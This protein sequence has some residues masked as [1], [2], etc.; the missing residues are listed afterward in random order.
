MLSLAQYTVLESLRDRVY[1]AFLIILAGL[2][3]FFVLL[4]SAA[5]GLHNYIVERLGWMTID[6][7]LAIQTSIYAV[8]NITRERDRRIL[9]FHLT[10]PQSRGFYLIGKTLGLFAVTTALA[11]LGT[12]IVFFGDR[13]F[14]YLTTW[15]FE[16]FW[17][18]PSVLLKNAIL[19]AYALFFVHIT[20]SGLTASLLTLATYMIGNASNELLMLAEK[21]GVFEQRIL[22]FVY[23]LF[24][25]LQLLDFEQL[26]LYQGGVPLGH[27]FTACLYAGSYIGIFL[28]LAWIIFSK[29][30]L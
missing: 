6:I 28:S 4:G 21:L 15:R 19:L 13:F 1:L 23:Y 14:T 3:F 24:P 10:L 27:F 2:S 30:D 8:S 22:T 17:L 5:W 16:L 7:L 9:H 12:L 26:A 20:T 29:K 25:N 18:V 11:I